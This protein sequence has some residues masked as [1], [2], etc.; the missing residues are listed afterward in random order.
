MN[1]V[2]NCILVEVFHLCED[3][4]DANT[5]GNED[6]FAA[7]LAQGRPSVVVTTGIVVA[8]GLLLNILVERPLLKLCRR[9]GGPRPP[10]VKPA[11]RTA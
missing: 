6:V 4:C 11:T 3:R 9:L 2:G 1:L 8:V 10:R 7:D 5:A